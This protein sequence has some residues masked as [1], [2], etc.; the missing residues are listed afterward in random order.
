[1]TT[2]EYGSPKE[3]RVIG[4]P[5]TGKTTDLAERV[6]KLVADGVKPADIIAVSFTRA[7]AAEITSRG[8][9]IPRENVSTLHAMGKRALASGNDIAETKIP[10]WNKEMGSGFSLSYFGTDL[11]DPMGSE[12]GGITRG[13]ADDV[14]NQYMI[15][16]AK[17]IPSSSWPMNVRNFARKWEQWK[18][19]NNFDD[20][21]DF[22]EKPYLQQ[23]PPP[24]NPRF[25]FFDEFQD[26]TAAEAR[27]VRYWGDAYLERYTISGDPD[28]CLY[29]FKG[30]SA[31]N[32]TNPPLP[33]EQRTILPQSYRIPAAV[34][35]EA[36]GWIQQIKNREPKEYRP[37]DE[38]GEVRRLYVEKPEMMDP[39]NEAK[40]YTW[41]DP[42]AYLNDAIEHYLPHGK[43]VMFLASCSYMLEPL[44]TLLRE[45]G[46]P[47]HNPYRSTKPAW[48][49]LGKPQSG[50]NG[51]ERLLAYLRI[52]HDVWGDGGTRI[53][54]IDDYIKWAS[55]L[56]VRGIF[57]G[58][59]RTKAEIEKFRARMADDEPER[60]EESLDTIEHLSKW[61]TD[62]GLTNALNQDLRWFEDNL[63]SIGKTNSMTYA[64]KVA[65]M[66]GG[67]ALMTEP[68]VIL[69][70]IHSVKG[71]WADCVY[72][73]P[74]MSRNGYM[75]YSTSY[76][77]DG[78]IRLFYVAM[79]RA[80][81]SLILCK[82]LPP[83]QV[84]FDN[85]KKN[86]KEK[87]YATLVR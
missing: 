72:L 83:Y 8:T 42:G 23:I 70:T 25:G 45:R 28:Q 29:S 16:R 6:A 35:R 4:P 5:G 48:N 59:D 32:L 63:L 57:R 13:V 30:S 79:T 11:D 15:L 17:L 24:G 75:E 26:F 10:D 12:N 85:Y 27:L 76:K 51:S 56:K 19:T 9:A 80:K 18:R 37:R 61:M 49:P 87:S 46:I 55:Q 41:M 1:M 81:E 43:R 33:P 36:E 62:E 7:T 74:D 52:S 86:T 20:F 53:W 58:G 47:F 44:E 65:R 54:T 40:M 31:H 68:Q 66:H 60:L 78:I 3:F 14:F 2:T 39:A 84:D 38:E 67:A 22:I 64:L 71:G 34:Q 82:G 77:R 21:Q 50:M 73:F 69:G